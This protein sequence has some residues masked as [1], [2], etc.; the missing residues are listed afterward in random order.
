[1][2]IFKKIML[3]MLIMGNINSVAF[4]MCT[5][6]AKQRAFDRAECA[7]A[8][9]EVARRKHGKDLEIFRGIALED[10]V[11]M[12]RDMLEALPADQRFEFVMYV[13]GWDDCAVLHQVACK[14][15]VEMVRVILDALP[16]Q[17]RLGAVIDERGLIS[18]MALHKAAMKNQV[19]MAR[20]ILE[21]LPV[22]QRYAAIM[23]KNWMGI[24]ALRSAEI[25]GHKN[26]EKVLIEYLEHCLQHEQEQSGQE[27]KKRSHEDSDGSPVAPKKQEKQETGSICNIM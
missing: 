5:F 2:K 14:N 20:V 24:T 16:E 9:A 7:L 4:G 27:S 22:E 25:C 23:H 3:S 12:V 18:T 1:M 13:R 11:A 19:E 10:Q 6:D 17:Q 26:V 21:A 8:K 15:Q